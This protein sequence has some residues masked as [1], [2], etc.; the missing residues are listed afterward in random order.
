MAVIYPQ[1]NIPNLNIL[2]KSLPDSNSGLVD[3]RKL[4][5]QHNIQIVEEEMEYGMSGYIE[6]RE[7]GWVI[8]ISKYDTSGRKNFTLAHELG[9]YWLHKH[10]IMD[11]RHED[12]I[13]LRDNEYTPIE[14]EANEFAADLL[15]PEEKF[16]DFI[17]RGE[18]NVRD[19]AEKFSV[20]INA[21]RYRAYKLGYS[22]R[23]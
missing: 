6:K 23:V 22:S 18:N 2:T 21:I 8:G 15:I 3:I 12:T 17:N 14:R 16:R 9:H 10:R 11:K 5:K 4:I 1:K 7:Q 20:S 19:L 13:L